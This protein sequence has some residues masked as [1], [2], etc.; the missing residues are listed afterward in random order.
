MSK[1]NEYRATAEKIK[2]LQTKLQNLS[3]DDSLKQEL[4]FE[5]KLRSLMEQYNK[6]L[7]DLISILEPDLRVLRRLKNKIPTQS[8]RLRKAKRYTNPHTQEAIE[9][10]G[11]NHK[12]LKE[13]KA[14]YG[15]N[16][17]ESWSVFV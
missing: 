1:I 7:T 5:E 13:W 14:K 11:G 3:T 4:E 17:V 2:E 8:K 10:K 6:T 9:T 12:T 15:S 16:V